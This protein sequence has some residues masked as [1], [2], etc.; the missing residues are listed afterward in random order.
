[1]SFT[2]RRVRDTK[3]SPKKVTSMGWILVITTLIRS[4]MAWKKHEEVRE[5]VEDEKKQKKWCGKQ[6]GM[7]FIGSM[8][9]LM[10]FSG[11][12]LSLGFTK[13][14]L[15]TL[16]R[17]Q[18]IDLPSDEYGHTN[19]LLLGEGDDSH[20]GV[21]L[22]DTIMIASIDQKKNEPPVLLSIPRDTY[23]LKTAKIGQGR[24]NSLYRDYKG[25]LLKKGMGKEDASKEAM[26]ELKDAIG[27]LLGIEIHRVIKINFSG[28]IAGIDTIGGIDITLD[29]DF[30]DPEYPGDH[31]DY[32]TFSLPAGLQHLDGATAL[33]F[34]RSRHST[35]DFSRSA[36]QQKII[37]AIIQKMKKDGIITNVSRM[38]S[39]QNILEKNIETTFAMSELLSLASLAAKQNNPEII[40]MQLSDQN[41]LYGSL[42]MKGGFLYAPPREEFDGAAVLLPVSLPPSPITW[43]QIQVLSSLLF[44]HRTWMSD[45]AP[46]IVITNA[47]AKPGSA[48]LLGQELER[49]GFI[50][51]KTRNLS[52]DK[53][54]IFEKSLLLMRQDTPETEKTALKKELSTFLG[55]T[56][57]LTQST[58]I[59]DGAFEPEGAD[60]VIILGKDFSYQPLQNL[61]K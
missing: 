10:L 47:G 56:L 51:E 22:T 23:L 19:I 27:S 16:M 34:A 2:V 21:D 1:M 29:A 18:I 53:K 4:L 57:S 52:K 59:I 11:V 33:K 7:I 43:K 35:S 54:N 45:H 14:F 30:T 25:Q 9:G 37:A 48:G 8:I 31:Y 36:R 60:I 17:S 42:A 49:Y 58:A 3:S 13:D 5:E 44:Q 26:N 12:V 15:V 55:T 39:I 6:C 20:E 46:R 50:I 61:L 32:V 28:F 38:N 40:T 24:I 41:G